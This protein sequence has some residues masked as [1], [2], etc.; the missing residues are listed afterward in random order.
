MKE[1]EFKKLDKVRK[2][3]TMKKMQVC[4]RRAKA[5]AYKLLFPICQSLREKYRDQIVQLI[6]TNNLFKLTSPFMNASD[7]TDC[8]CTRVLQRPPSEENREN[9]PAPPSEENRDNDPP[10]PPEDN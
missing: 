9:D 1:E 7:A 2:T 3:K 5:R 8:T 10:P 6:N 4:K